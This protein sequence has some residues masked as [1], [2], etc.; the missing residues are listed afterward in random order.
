MRDFFPLSM[1]VYVNVQH[2]RMRNMTSTSF[3]SFFWVL[4]VVLLYGHVFDE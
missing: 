2:A 4:E 3:F 1:P